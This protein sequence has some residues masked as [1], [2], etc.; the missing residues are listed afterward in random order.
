[1]KLRKASKHKDLDKYLGE[2]WP[3]EL[4]S[5]FSK[6]SHGGNAEKNPQKIILNPISKDYK[7]KD[8]NKS[9]AKT[10]ISNISKS[11]QDQEKK[12][13]KVVAAVEKILADRFGKLKKAVD[14]SGEASY[15]G[16]YE[17]PLREKL[18]ANFKSAGFDADTAHY[19]VENA[20]DE[21]SQESHENLVTFAE[22]LFA[23]D[24][25]K[26]VEKVATISQ[27]DR[28]ADP[29]LSC[30]E[31]GNP[32]GDSNVN[33][34]SEMSS[35]MMADD[36]TDAG[37]ACDEDSKVTKLPYEEPNP[38]DLT[39]FD[40][41]DAGTK[42]AD[43]DEPPAGSGESGEAFEAPDEETYLRLRE[44]FIGE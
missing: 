5:A 28:Q 27:L 17:N 34:M 38:E 32:C 8:Q 6:D 4:A 10:Q 14:T 22:K 37:K 30:D 24:N 15:K 11:W 21:A 3:K 40:L 39:P 23:L 36:D 13:Y 2:A 29:A 16:I 25:S 26:F 41:P 12:F 42:P 9:D 35:T 7:Q 44:K 19:I 33:M 43:Q 31:E 20:F 1:M 18:Y